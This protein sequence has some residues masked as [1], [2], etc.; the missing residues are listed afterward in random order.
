MIGAGGFAT[1]QVTVAG[2]VTLIAAARPGRHAVTIINEGTTDV[3]LGRADVTTG[4]G[5]LL[6]GTKGASVTIP[7]QDAVYGIVAVGSQVVSV[8]ESYG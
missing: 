7:T 2:T 4:T 1:N 5:A 3:R 6:T 8:A